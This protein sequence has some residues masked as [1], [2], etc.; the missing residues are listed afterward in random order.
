M[1]TDRNGRPYANVDEVEAGCYLQPDNQWACMASS[2]IKLV[3]A[4]DAGKLYIDCANGRHYLHGTKNCNDWYTG[5][6]LYRP[7]A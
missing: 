4:D 6:Y 1:P 3:K 5:L 7:D 2:E